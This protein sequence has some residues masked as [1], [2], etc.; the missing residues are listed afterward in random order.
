MVIDEELQYVWLEAIDGPSLWTVWTLMGPWEFDRRESVKLA[1]MPGT[2]GSAAATALRH[3][4][5]D[6][7]G[8][9][10]PH[11]LAP[12]APQLRAGSTSDE[13]VGSVGPRWPGSGTH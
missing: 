5:E 9:M 8:S 2:S 12:E 13:P 7:L 3:E 1:R 11:H 6:L 4:Q 10:D